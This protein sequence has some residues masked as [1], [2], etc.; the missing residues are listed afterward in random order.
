MGRNFWVAKNI[1]LTKLANFL[2]H[3]LTF[4]TGISRKTRFRSWLEKDAGA[5]NLELVGG[6]A[7]L[8]QAI[9][10]GKMMDFLQPLPVIW[11]HLLKGHEGMKKHKMGGMNSFPSFLNTIEMC[12]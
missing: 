1:I 10:K 5:Q 12:S 4:F 7:S 11:L 8:R 6:G 2:R 9:Q 3:F